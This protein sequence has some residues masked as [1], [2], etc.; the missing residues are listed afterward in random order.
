MEL[1]QNP[2]RN[3]T[4]HRRNSGVAKLCPPE[5]SVTRIVGPRASAGPK[6]F[7][8][9][10]PPRGKQPEFFPLH[11][12]SFPSCFIFNVSPIGD[13]LRVVE[14]FAP[15]L[16][17]ERPPVPHKAQN[18][19]P[20]A[21]TR[22]GESFAEMCGA[23]EP[24]CSSSHE[25]D[26][27]WLLWAMAGEVI[28]EAEQCP[29]PQRRRPAVRRQGGANPGRPNSG[30]TYSTISFSYRLGFKLFAIDVYSQLGPTD[31][32]PRL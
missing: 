24:A 4:D 7:Q 11:S 13:T 6:L 27:P 2:P 30:T 29:E 26:Y 25:R 16:L 17:A 8:L 28:N 20:K 14:Q 22:F 23:L 15:D 9:R 18:I 31:A 10:H 32:A 1:P 3:L 12:S 19:M 5:R 21:F